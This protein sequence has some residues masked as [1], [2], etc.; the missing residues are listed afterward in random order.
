MMST[1]VSDMDEPGSDK[2]SLSFAARTRVLPT[3]AA[4]VPVIR[5]AGDH[6]VL[7]VLI[8]VL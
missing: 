3:F 8:R 4:P 1:A 6:A 2:R 5:A 7:A